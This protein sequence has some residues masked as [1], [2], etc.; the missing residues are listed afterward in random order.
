M[1]K[2]GGIQVIGSYKDL[3]IPQ[4]AQKYSLCV[5]GERLN[6][7]SYAATTTT[8]SGTSSESELWDYL[9]SVSIFARMS[10]DDKERVLKRLKQQGRHT[11][12]CG[13]GANDVGALKQAHVGVA[14]LSGFGSANTK[15]L[16]QEGGDESKG[17]EEGDGEKGKKLAKENVPREDAKSERASGKSEEGE[18]GG[19]NRAS[20][21]HERTPS[22]AKSLVR[23]RVQGKNGARRKVGAVYRHEKFYATN[24][25]RIKTQSDGKS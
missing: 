1:D 11:Y 21:R 6:A 8:E 12:M 15:K 5:T 14:L 22:V 3:S 4:L 10:P 17:E 16:K 25:S 19:E 2:D 23:G 18:N 9:D 24:D 7:A 20:K 13:D